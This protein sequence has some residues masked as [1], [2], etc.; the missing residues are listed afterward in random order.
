MCNQT[1]RCGYSS[2]ALVSKNAET[3][4]NRSMLT[5]PSN[6]LFRKEISSDVV[7]WC[8]GARVNWRTRPSNRI[9]VD[10]CSPVIPVTEQYGL[11]MDRPAAKEHRH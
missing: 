6:K 4:V 11:P 8:I 5:I 3:P 1:S 7:L 2:E 10:L 9:C